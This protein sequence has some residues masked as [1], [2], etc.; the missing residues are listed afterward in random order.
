MDAL[1]RLAWALPLVLLIGMA[2]L[3][4]LK[5]VVRATPPSS[6]HALRLSLRESLS[7]S[8]ETRVHLIDLDGTAC[9]VVESTR[10]ATLHLPAL[11]AESARATTGAGP[12]W[13]RRF[14]RTSSR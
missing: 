6:G 10:H 7:L 8:D 13:L 1:G 5:R 2:A 3:L 14:Y 11:P 12:A 9:L 4:L